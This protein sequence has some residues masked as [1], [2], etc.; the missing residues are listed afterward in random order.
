M[1]DL[2]VEKA[3]SLF[4]D[5]YQQLRSDESFA[6]RCLQNQDPQKRLVALVFLCRRT[7]VEL[8]LKISLC[9][10]LMS[11]DESDAVALNAISLLADLQSGTFDDKTSKMF[12]QFVLDSSRTSKSRCAAFYAIEK[13]RTP[14]SLFVGSESITQ[15]CDRIKRRLA[16]HQEN[17]RRRCTPNLDEIDWD[18]IHAL[19]K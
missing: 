18:L 11:H 13:I 19:A 3:I 4:G 10:K 6:I 7:S 1:K 16:Q 8:D 12:A 2:L 15:R 9:R 14:V 5:E 17:A